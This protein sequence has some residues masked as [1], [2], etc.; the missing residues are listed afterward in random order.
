MKKPAAALGKAEPKKPAAKKNLKK[1]DLE[2]LGEL[3][4]KE[5][6]K[7]VMAENESPEDQAEAL[8]KVMSPEEKSK[9]WGRHQT[10]LA[11]N[12]DKQA[13][14]NQLSKGQKG[15]ATVMWLVH[16][17]AQ[18]F[19]HVSEKMVEKDSFKKTEFWMTEK[20]ALDKWTQAELDKHIASGR[21]SWREAPGTSE[22][23]E[24]RDNQDYVKTTKNIHASE[25]KRSQEYAMTDEDHPE[26]DEW[27]NFDNMVLQTLG[28]GKSLGKGSG[29]SGKG[30]GKGKKKVKGQVQEAEPEEASE[31]ALLNTG[32]LKLRKCRDS[33]LREVTDFEESLDKVKSST[34]MSSANLEDKLTV[35]KE[36]QSQ[37]QKVK[38]SLAK[39]PENALDD[40]KGLLV[41]SAQVLKQGREDMKELTQLANKT[42]SKI[43][44]KK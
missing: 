28:K 33:L 2:A 10:W 11:K 22:V 40:I 44:R 29:D 41:E 35:L 26:W 38:Q 36:L 21:V 4:L 34:Y 31:E 39:G 32:L 3:S 27:M 1:E 13:E 16:V 25:Y 20:Q 37:L 30:K 43:S 9:A 14:F 42:S 6:V 24:Y 23:W 18:Q 8:K 12:K 7:K 5:K 17:E 15:L 19:G